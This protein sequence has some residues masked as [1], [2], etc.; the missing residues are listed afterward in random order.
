MK[1]GGDLVMMIGNAWVTRGGVRL[2]RRDIIRDRMRQDLDALDHYATQANVA[3]SFAYDGDLEPLRS[4]APGAA[5]RFE[6]RR[7]I[8]QMRR[9]LTDG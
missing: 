3:P 4:I 9:A 6:L 2:S 5:G 7:Q 8:D 1:G